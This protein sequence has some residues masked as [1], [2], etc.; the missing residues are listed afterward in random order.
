MYKNWQLYFIDVIKSKRKGPF[1]SLLRGLLHIPSWGFRFIVACRNWAFDHQYFS[2]YYPPIPVVISIGNI[3]AGGT[4]KTPVTLMLAK[5]F[6]PDIPIAILSRG[7]KSPAEKLSSSTMLS[8][9][10]GPLFPASY[11]GDESYLLAK[12]LPKA[13]VV[14]GRDRHAAS[15]MASHAGAQILLLDDGMQHRRLARDFEIVVLDALDPFGQGYFLPRGFLRESAASLARADLLVLNHVPTPDY[16]VSLKQQLAS[17]T[18]APIV[19]TK[20]VVADIMDFNDQPIKPI[21]NKQVG[22]FCGIAK[23][24][25]FQQTVEQLGAQVVAHHFLPDHMDIDSESLAYFAEECYSKGAEMIVCTEK[26][27]VK[28]AN[29]VQIKL[30]IVWLQMRL[31]IVDGNEHWNAL[32]SKIEKCAER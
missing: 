2:R 8:E 28:F 27:R 9:G 4:G 26:D 6:Y 20:M 30:P 1:A 19:T 11:C 3:V 13:I 5:E 25:R 16:V 22:I 17:Y 15:D 12:N 32:I 7:Y 21:Q 29:P 24:E 23:P 18:T 31:S 14:V 10:A